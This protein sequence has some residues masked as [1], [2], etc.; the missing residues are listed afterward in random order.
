MHSFL[1][2]KN[3][4]FINDHIQPIPDLY[5]PFWICVT[6]IFSIAIFGNF[7]HYIQ[8]SGVSRTYEND[9]GLGSFFFFKFN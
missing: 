8:N 1:P 3:S 7:A 2:I 5:G 9:F 6:L 4:N